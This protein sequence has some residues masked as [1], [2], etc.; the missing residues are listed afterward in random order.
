MKVLLWATVVCLLSSACQTSTCM[1][2][3]PFTPE[4]ASA[5]VLKVRILDMPDKMVDLNHCHG[6]WSN[7]GKCCDVNDLILA[8]KLDGKLIDA[9]AQDLMKIVG[10]AK[11]LLTIKLEETYQKS[12]VKLNDETRKQINDLV[13]SAEFTKF[14]ESTKTC[15]NFMKKQRSSAL[16]SICSGDS[17]IYFDNG[18]ILVDQQVCTQTTE[19]CHAFFETLASMRNLLASITPALLDAEYI[20]VVKPL[21]SLVHSLDEGMPPASLLE[22]F[23]VYSQTLKDKTAAQDDLELLNAESL[24]CSTILNILMTPYIMTMNSDQIDIIIK[25]QKIQLKARHDQALVKLETNYNQYI[26]TR[27]AQLKILKSDLK[28]N[29]LKI[30]TLQDEISKKDKQFK[31]ESQ[32]VRA[33]FKIANRVLCDRIDKEKSAWRIADKLRSQRIDKMSREELSQS[34]AEYA[35]KIPRQ[36]KR[37]K[38]KG[39]F[40]SDSKMFD[41]KGFIKKDTN[42]DRASSTVIQAHIK[43]KSCRM[44]DFP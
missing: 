22:A 31:D 17:S 6:E 37:V 13:E 2:L 41:A 5:G 8:S 11:W 44:I 15:W 21:H 39:L 26:Q 27:K 4:L 34:I 9:N 42:R 30:K 36:L 23:K 28:N 24:V 29:A 25:M 33:E 40:E 20:R 1:A 19:S 43:K 16:C 7:H 18:K 38:S 3:N 35:S 12:K 10:N 14:N 32:K